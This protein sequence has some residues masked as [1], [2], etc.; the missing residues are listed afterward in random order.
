MHVLDA[1]GNP[2]RRTILRRLKSRPMS[3]REIARGFSVSRPAISRHLAILE[4]SGLVEAK[5]VGTRNVYSVRVQGLS[6]VRAFV[7]EFWSA[8]LERLKSLEPQ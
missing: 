4:E 3:V 7:D 5:A 2:T 8:A 1:L 6:T